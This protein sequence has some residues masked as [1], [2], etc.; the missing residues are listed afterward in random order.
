MKANELRIGNYILNHHKEIDTVTDHTFSKFRFAKMDGDYGVY[1]IEL[2]EEWLLKFG[3]TCIKNNRG[4]YY[5]LGKITIYV[6]LPDKKWI[7]TDYLLGSHLSS[8]SYVHQLQNLYF[9]L[10][11][12]ELTITEK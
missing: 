12:E 7:V 9:A 10:T 2:T 5:V 8:I 6:P 1:P 11:G 4:G 3:F